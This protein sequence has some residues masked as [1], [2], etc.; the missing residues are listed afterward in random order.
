MVEPLLAVLR[1][2]GRNRSLAPL[3]TGMAETFFLSFYRRASML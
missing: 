3:A 1:E 2:G